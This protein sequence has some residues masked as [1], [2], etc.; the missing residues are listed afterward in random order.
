[1]SGLYNQLVELGNDKKLIAASEVGAAP[2]PDLLQL[3]EAHW[4]WFAVWTAPFINDPAWNSLDVLREVRIGQ[5]RCSIAE[6]FA[7][8]H[9]QVYGS[10]YVL[11]LSEIQG[12]QAAHS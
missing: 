7:N 10:D 11:T 5:K 8:S 9:T 2:L 6:H 12:W 3:Y 4:L 1:M